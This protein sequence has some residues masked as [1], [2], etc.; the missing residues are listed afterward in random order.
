MATWMNPE[1]IM[2]NEENQAHKDKY[3][4]SSIRYETKEG[5]L[6]E[7]RE[8]QVRTVVTEAG[9]GEGGRTVGN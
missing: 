1:N 5:N 3:P 4:R 8:Q 2:F 6:I 7:Q 9:K